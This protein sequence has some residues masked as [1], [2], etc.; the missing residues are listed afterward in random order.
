VRPGGLSMESE[1]FEQICDAL[2]MMGLSRVIAAPVVNHACR[3]VG[4]APEQLRRSD[5]PKLGVEL[6]RS[7]R[8]Y[9]GEQQVAEGL[10]R[11]YTVGMSEARPTTRET[12]QAVAAIRPRDDSTKR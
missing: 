9:L 8:M 6:E 7:L 3:I 1:T 10:R 2:A 4:L 12:L 5:V 11:V